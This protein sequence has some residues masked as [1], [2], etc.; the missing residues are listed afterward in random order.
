MNQW[1]MAIHTFFLIARSRVD[2][3]SMSQ[4][5]ASFIRY[6]QQVSMA[7]QALL[8]F[9]RRIGS[10]AVFG[11]IVFTLNEMNKDIFNTMKSLLVEKIKGVVGGR[12]M[13]IHAIGHKTLGVVNMG[14]GLPAVVGGLNLVAT[15]TK[16]GRR[17]SHHGVVADAE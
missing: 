5:C 14:G 2:H 11:L 7:L 13:A 6:I 4:H 10:F 15:C 16:L 17:S 3:G 12:Q 1:A 9:K 8:V